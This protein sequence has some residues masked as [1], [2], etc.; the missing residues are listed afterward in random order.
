MSILPTAAARDNRGRFAASTSP[1]AVTPVL[2]VPAWKFGYRVGGR[3]Y[4]NEGHARAFAESR[5]RH[6]EGGGR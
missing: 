3:I 1:F 4:A 2:L 6:T 5:R